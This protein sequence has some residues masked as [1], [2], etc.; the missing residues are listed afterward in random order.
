MIAWIYPMT[1][2][3]ALALGGALSMSSTAIVTKILSD[4]MELETEQG[5]NVVGILLLQDLAVVFL[6]ILIPSLAQSG[7][8]LVIDIAFALVKIFL[9]LVLIFTLAKMS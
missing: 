3:A 7:K 8:D 1:W 9:A 2:Q 5:R 6:L 4:R